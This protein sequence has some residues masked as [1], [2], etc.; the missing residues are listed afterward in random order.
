MDLAQFWGGDIARSPTGG[1]AAVSGTD[2]G[3]QRVL[4]RLLTNPGDYIWHP[5]YGAGLARRI[6]ETLDLRAIEAVIREQMALEAA[7][8]ADPAPVIGVSTIANGVFVSIS[9]VDANLG[10]PAGLSFQVPG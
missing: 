3:T 7:V 8:A 6:G 1:L 10:V 4:R 2:Y 9:Y 5:S